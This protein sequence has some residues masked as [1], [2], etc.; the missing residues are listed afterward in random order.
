MAV[1]QSPASAVRSKPARSWPLGWH[2][3]LFAL[4]LIAP[5]LGFDILAA[6]RL[7]HAERAAGEEQARRIA[8]TV[9]A[10]IDRELNRLVEV[11]EALAKSASLSDGD[12][13]GFHRDAG[14]V[15]AGTGYAVLLIDPRHNQLVNTRVPYGTPLPET[16][17]LTTARKVFAT[18]KPAVG[19]LFIGQVQHEPRIALMVPAVLDGDVRYAAVLSIEPAALTRILKQH[20]LP[21]GWVARV[22]DGKGQI[23]A[24]ST[25]SEELVGKPAQAD[26]VGEA[27]GRSDVLKTKDRDGVPVLLAHHTS[28][29]S[30][31]S[32]AAWAP[33]SIID[34]PARQLWQE[35]IALA[36]LALILSLVGA[37]LVGRWL[38]HPI[39]G[40]ASAAAALGRGAPVVYTPCAIAEVNV[41]GTAL[42]AA[43]E[44]V[45]ILMRELSHR[46]K[47]VMAVVNA[48]A[49]QTAR[50]AASLKDFEERF[51][52]RLEA[53]GRSQD[54]LV[55]RDWQGVAVE[56]LVRAQLEPFLDSADQRLSAHGPDLLLTPQAAQDLGMAL[57]E[58]A[59]NAS[60]YGALSVPNG[61]IEIDWVVD[62]GTVNGHRF[63][64]TWR[65]SGGPIVSPPDH[66]G[67][68]SQVL[69]RTLAASFK[70][71]ADLEYRAE[72]LMWQLSAPMGGLIAEPSPAAVPSGP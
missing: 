4:A 38:A 54:L 5:L 31:W 39:V 24:K 35:L 1:I 16:G 55:K 42:A 70:G 3:Y 2:L 15:M 14:A 12:L 13:A 30:G 44:H 67:F 57:H 41:V 37:A 11:L 32:T 6:S 25:R 62:A 61:K 7:G 43:A 29:L 21:D 26:Y 9:T 68:G 53:L 52:H 60:K 65:E 59:T 63:L 28:P 17:D 66:T 18:G 22:A 10:S 56:D 40:V 34:A 49:W 23:I 36:G 33:L 50:G 72:G 58:L 47:N 20:Y 27:T 48:I 8:R 71:K 19:D 46:T 64:M 69:T 51:T 45:R